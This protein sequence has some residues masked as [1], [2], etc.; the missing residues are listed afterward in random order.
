MYCC[1]KCG[2]KLYIGVEKCP[3]CNTIIDK[4]IIADLAFE[5][6][7]KEI[8]KNCPTIPTEHKINFSVDKCII[9]ISNDVFIMAYINQFVSNIQRKITEQ[10]KH[11]FHSWSLDVLIKDGELFVDSLFLQASY[12]I[13]GFL[14]KNKGSVSQNEKE[15][16][17]ESINFSEVVWWPIY[18]IAEQLEEFKSTLKERRAEIKTQRRGYWVGG[19]FGIKG[20][21]KGQIKADIMNA[22]GGVFNSAKTVGARG[23]QAMWDNSQIN[24]LKKELHKDPELEQT[25]FAELEKCFSF[26]RE[27]LFNSLCHDS[28]NFHKWDTSIYNHNTE[29]HKISLET[30]FN[31]LSV[32]PFDIAAYARIYKSNT[33]SG[34]ELS[35]IAI[36]CGVQEMVWQEFLIVDNAIFK[37]EKFDPQ[38]IGIDTN[39]E[40]LL[41]IKSELISLESTNPAY[42]QSYSKSINKLALNE[43]RYHKKVDELLTLIR[44]NEINDWIAELS[45]RDSF[46]EIVQKFSDSNDDIANQCVFKFFLHILYEIG[47]PAFIAKFEGELPVLANDAVYVYRF[48]KK[49]DQYKNSIEALAK[50]GRPNPMAYYGE[51][52]YNKYGSE[53]GIE[54]LTKAAKQMSS[55]AL[56]YVASFYQTGSAGFERDPIIAK[57]Y[58]TI[59]AAWNEAKAKQALK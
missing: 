23:V 24:K 3:Y 32:N 57:S 43:R 18:F 55:L 46:K 41:Q 42:G 25:I 27:F 10:I 15:R 12:S 30:A 39:K 31:T 26:Y 50:L 54:F 11:R 35:Q 36:F 8:S 13:L 58:F 53:D 49:P 52:C 28:T 29:K 37:D 2:H 14:Y 19:G 48:I 4:Q 22:A 38:N 17:L 47:V 59:A 16:I 44:I 51:Y 1:Y 7:L 9:T 33:K 21:I 20:A 34:N 6:T 40:A 56:A 45:Q 5:N